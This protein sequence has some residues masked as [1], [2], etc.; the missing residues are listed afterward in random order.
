[1]VA[2][3]SAIDFGRSSLSTRGSCLLPRLCFGFWLVLSLRLD[4]ACCC[5][6]LVLVSLAGSLRMFIR[7][8]ELPE[9]CYGHPSS[10]PSAGV[11]PFASL[12]STRPDHLQ[13]AMDGV[14]PRAPAVERWQAGMAQ[15]MRRINPL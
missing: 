14:V 13:P 1:M 11:Q 8:D 7:L 6:Q 5:T 15:V 3:G 10:N 2:G 9:V 12:T 4:L